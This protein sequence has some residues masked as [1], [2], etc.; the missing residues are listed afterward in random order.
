MNKRLR[1]LILAVVLI[2]CSGISA[3]AASVNEVQKQQTDTKN[4]LN[5]INKSITAIENKRKS[6]NKKIWRILCWKI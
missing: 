3:M 1:C 4:K 2:F 6:P 5:E